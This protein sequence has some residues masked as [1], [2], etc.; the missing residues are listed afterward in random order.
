M[1]TLTLNVYHISDWIRLPH[2]YSTTAMT[3]MTRRVSRIS[4][5]LRV[6]E[7]NPVLLLLL[8]ACLCESNP[9][10]V[11]LSL[12][13]L[14]LWH[15]SCL[16]KRFCDPF[17][18]MFNLAIF[19]EGI[20]RSCEVHVIATSL[21]ALSS[22][23]AAL[24]PGLC[25]PLHHRFVRGLVPS[26]SQSR[27]SRDSGQRIC[28]CAIAGGPCKVSTRSVRRYTFDGH[29]AQSACFCHWRS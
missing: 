29:V 9:V 27:A 5:R 25:P 13:C 6:S 22:R 15:L 4:I 3:S 26:H 8:L 24:S 2:R 21:F 18:H 1:H 28:Q 7:S 19:G 23:I 14:C 12:A 17:C 16:F 10:L 20:Q 11:L